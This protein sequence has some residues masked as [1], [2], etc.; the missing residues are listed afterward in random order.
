MKNQLTVRKM[1]AAAVI[2][3]VYAALSMALAPISYGPIQ[4][5]I[6]EVLCI[7]PFF[8]PFSTWGLFLGC[9]I[10]NLLSAYG[11]LDIVFGS[12]ATLLAALCTAGFGK[13]S[14]SV[15]SKAAGCFMPVLFNGII[16]GAVIAWSETNGG[17]AFLPAYLLDA[18]TVAFGEAAV[19]YVIGLPLMINLPKTRFFCDILDK[20]GCGVKKQEEAI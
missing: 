7:L 6:S 14:R 20:F 15:V 19:L 13:R 3:A 9:I 1:A 2:A 4:F 11:P 8:L 12:L 18:G 16:V 17:D 10:A 5:R